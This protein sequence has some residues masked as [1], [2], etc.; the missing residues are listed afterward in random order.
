M[1]TQQQ[2]TTL[3]TH[4]T[5][6]GNLKHSR[7]GWL[8]LTPA[9]SIHLVS[10]L[11]DA[12]PKMEAVV[13]D[14]FCGTGT[15]ALVCSERGIPANTVDINP[16]LIWLTTVK[17]R[18]YKPTELELF[19]RACKTI[20]FAIGDDSDQSSWIP[21]LYKIEKWWDEKTLLA[22]GRMMFHI[23]EMESSFPHPV[24]DL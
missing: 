11:L 3:A 6:K 12:L 7:Y 1:L 22:I 5:H 8:R 13:L 24:I 21:P 23:R 19:D 14:P 20:C 10:Q 9:Y 18:S 4:L 2:N 15:T 16:F 17:T